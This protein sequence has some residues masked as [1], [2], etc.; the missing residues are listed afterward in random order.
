MS[1]YRT[2]LFLF[3]ALLV[4]CGLWRPFSSGVKKLAKIPAL[5]DLPNARNVN[6]GAEPSG[7]AAVLGR[8]QSNYPPAA[9]CEPGDPIY[10][11]AAVMTSTVAASTQAT[12]GSVEE[13]F[14]LIPKCRGRF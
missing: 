12:G 3:L 9:A 8:F 13:T 6:T 4:C 7:S 5:Q 10:R 11:S 14:A 2:F 1:P